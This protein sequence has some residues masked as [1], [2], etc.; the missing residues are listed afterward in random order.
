MI[1]NDVDS[2]NLKTYITHTF[3]QELL[4]LFDTEESRRRLGAHARRADWQTLTGSCSVVFWGGASRA[5]SAY[6]LVWAERVLDGVGVAEWDF[7]DYEEST[8][9]VEIFGNW[10][11]HYRLPKKSQKSHGGFSLQGIKFS[12][13]IWWGIVPILFCHVRVQ[14]PESL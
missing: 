13:R 6:W 2:K 5:G 14:Y 3:I 7:E 4:F 12:R 9:L 10:R 1:I 8:G 11:R